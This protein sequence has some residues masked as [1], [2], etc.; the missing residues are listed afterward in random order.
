M[1]FS[2]RQLAGRDAWN[3]KVGGGFQWISEP[4]AG[5]PI[6]WSPVRSLRTDE[7]RWVPAAFVYYGFPGA[8]ARFCDGD[9]NGLA[10]GNCVEEAVLQGLLEVVERDAVALWWYNR[11]LRPRVEIPASGDQWFREVQACHAA[12]GRALWALDLTSDVGLPVRAALSARDGREI[13]FGF[14]RTW[15]PALRCDAPSPR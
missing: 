7:V 10:S 13:I 14:G 5:E 1:H 3:E 6:E 4:Y 9:S 11:V 8:G 12:N 2:E 15:I